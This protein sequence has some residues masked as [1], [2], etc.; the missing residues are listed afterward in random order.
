M[1]HGGD[2]YNNRIEYDFSV[3]TN[4]LGAPREIYESVE[5]M[6]GMFEHYPQL[7]SGQLKSSLANKLGINDEYLV[8]GNGASE[9]LMAICLGLG[10]Q[11]VFVTNPSFTGYNHVINA[12]KA[13]RVEIAL[14]ENDD[15]CYRT[16][17]LEAALEAAPAIEKAERAVLILTSP[18]N[19]TG[20]CI[21][22]DEMQRTLKLCES[23]NITVVLDEC[24]VRLCDDPESSMI[25]AVSQYDNLI[26]VSAFTKTFAVAGVRLGY[27]VC[28]NNAL[29]EAVEGVIPEWNVSTV[30]Q[31]VGLMILEQTDIESYLQSSRE[32]IAREREYL[33]GQMREMGIKVYPSNANYL[34]IG[35]GPGIDLY[36]K[37]ID[38]GILI[39]DCTDYGMK[40]EGYY[41]IAVKN[42][43]E[44]VIFIDKL[45]E[46][47]GR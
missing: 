20:R 41:R 23:N 9:L 22:Q 42:H 43:D 46:I 38:E 16:E 19:P 12:C 25:D 14:P 1:G 45:K 3:N 15:F 24:F 35:V 27:M 26:I 7:C 32:V 37:M 34:L 8:M 13:R 39:R 21:G 5:K 6:P 2:I 40:A 17:Y 11:T 44:N 18:N 36:G 33:A 29:R 4:P 30:A 10:P 31:R 47:L 28:A